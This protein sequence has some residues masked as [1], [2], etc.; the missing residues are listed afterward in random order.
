MTSSGEKA[1]AIVR[2]RENMP[3]AVTNF[4]DES[5]EK[6]EIP[7]TILRVLRG[8]N[9]SGLLPTEGHFLVEV[10]V[11]FV[12][13]CFGIGSNNHINIQNRPTVN[14]HLDCYRHS[15]RGGKAI[16]KIRNSLNGEL[17]RT[18]RKWRK[19]RERREERG[20]IP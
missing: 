16:E 12:R 2:I 3:P 5:L 13:D 6:I 17:N 7:E 19:I 14:V 1:V 15:S 11:R 20:L 9:N 10:K 18:N 4:V 8:R